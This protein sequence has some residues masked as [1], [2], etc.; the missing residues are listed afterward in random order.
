[1][2][3]IE[4][5]REWE[6]LYDG[7]LV[8]HI[9][10]SDCKTYPFSDAPSPSDGQGRPT[11]REVHPVVRRDLEAEKGRRL[12]DKQT[13]RL[14][15]KDQEASYR[16]DPNCYNHPDRP[17]SGNPPYLR[18]S[19]RGVR[20]KGRKINNERGEILVLVDGKPIAIFPHSTNSDEWDGRTTSERDALKSARA[21]AKAERD[22]PQETGKVD[23]LQGPRAFHDDL[24]EGEFRRFKSQADELLNKQ[25]IRTTGSSICGPDDTSR[26]PEAK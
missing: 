22:K 24:K 20:I 6:S 26:E 23:R 14:I 9:P 15:P 10:F 3:I 2:R 11:C 8:L 5:T 12:I 7:R 25:A 16:N 19:L 17:D 4:I 13:M 18:P 1:M 21:I